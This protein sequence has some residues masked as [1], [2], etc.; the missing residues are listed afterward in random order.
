MPFLQGTNHMRVDLIFFHTKQFSQATL[1]Y[2]WGARQLSQ[3][4]LI[5]PLN[6]MIRRLLGGDSGALCFLRYRLMR[7]IYKFGNSCGLFIA[8]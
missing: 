8:M 3:S 7:A 4:S 2:T 1:C 6:A 5:T